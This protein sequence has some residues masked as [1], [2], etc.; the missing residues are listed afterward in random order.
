MVT[1]MSFRFCHD[2]IFPRRRE[3][4]HVWATLLTAKTKDFTMTVVLPPYEDMV[5]S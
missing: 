3:E 1:S 4:Y 5:A 2:E